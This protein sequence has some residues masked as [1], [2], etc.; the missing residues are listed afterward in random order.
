L[1]KNRGLAENIS[2]FFSRFFDFLGLFALQA[3]AFQPQPS[4]PSLQKNNAQKPTV[5]FSVFRTC[6]KLAV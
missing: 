2:H 3:I 5:G 4:I 1:Q 6:A